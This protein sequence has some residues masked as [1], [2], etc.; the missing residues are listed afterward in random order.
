MRG[1]YGLDFETPYNNK[2]DPQMRLPFSYCRCCG[3]EIYSE[4]DYYCNEGMCLACFYAA[5][6]PAPE[7]G[8]PDCEYERGAGYGG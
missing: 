7:D 6:Q 4:D 2:H 5:K 3:A 8:D 1:D